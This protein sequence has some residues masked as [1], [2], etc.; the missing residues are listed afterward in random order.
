MHLFWK[1]P[2]PSSDDLLSRI[3]AQF[4]RKH[5]S[6]SVFSIGTKIYSKSINTNVVSLDRILTHSG[7]YFIEIKTEKENIFSQKIVRF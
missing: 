2:S 6:I 3:L 5:L 4:K 1:L 7:I